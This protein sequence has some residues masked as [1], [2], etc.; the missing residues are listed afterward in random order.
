M[1]ILKVPPRNLL[2]FLKLLVGEELGVKQMLQF[3]AVTW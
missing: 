3:V 2:S 1:L